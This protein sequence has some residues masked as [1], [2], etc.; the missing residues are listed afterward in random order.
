MDDFTLC[1][2]TEYKF[3]QVIFITKITLYATCKMP[4]LSVTVRVDECKKKHEIVKTCAII[5]G[6]ESDDVL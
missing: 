6:E 2:T 1:R 4:G 3:I 5:L